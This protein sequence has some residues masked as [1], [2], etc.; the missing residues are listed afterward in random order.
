MNKLKDVLE[1]RVNA[2]PKIDLQ[3]DPGTGAYQP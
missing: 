3:Y 2:K 1:S